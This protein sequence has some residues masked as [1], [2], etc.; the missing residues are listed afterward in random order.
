MTTA[1]V[2]HAS[3]LLHRT[4]PGVADQ[5]ARLDFVTRALHDLPLKRVDAPL[6]TEDQIT[7]MHDA[8]YV[9]KVLGGCPDSGF[10]FFDADT[11]AE[12]C[13]SPTS[14][15]AVL[16]SVGG[17]LH[18]VDLVM[19]GSAAN[20]FV[21]MRPPGHHALPDR[22]MGFCFFGNIALAAHHA[23]TV[24][25]VNKLAIVDF[26]VHHG[27]GT[28][29]MVQDDP[30]VLFI[31]SQQ[32]LLWPESGLADETGPHDTVLNLPLAPGSTGAEMRIAFANT[33]FPRVRAFQPDLILVSAGF[34]AHRDDPLAELNWTEEDY[35]WLARSFCAIANA[36]CGGRIVSVLEGGYDLDAL[37]KSARAYVQALLRASD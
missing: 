5:V 18:A 30:R 34:D 20:A 9:S 7:P 26:D 11:D 23:L 29:H 4:P 27:N 15:E 17:A 12:T 24:H 2:T 37:G 10:S 33:V 14:R 21:A 16:R 8:E 6:A 13:L 32:V 28:Q 25:G 1:L 35:N 36:C 22:A 3:G 31:S 19:S